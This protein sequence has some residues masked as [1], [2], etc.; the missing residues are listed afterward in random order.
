MSSLLCILD[1]REI[2]ESLPD[3]NLAK[4]VVLPV[5]FDATSSYRLGSASAPYA[6]IEATNQIDTYDLKFYDN[7]LGNVIV[8]DPILEAVQYNEIAR[9]LYRQSLNG[10]FKSLEVLNSVCG[11]VFG[12][13]HS[14]TKFW[15]D[16]GK[17]PI[18][19]GGDNSVSV[20]PVVAY[21]ERYVN[22][23]V[24]HF[25]AHADLRADYQ[26]CI[27]S[28]AA[29]ISNI[30][31]FTNCCVTQVG[32][33]D[34]CED[35]HR[36]I[37]DS[38]GRIVPFFARDLWSESQYVPFQDISSRIAAT[39]SRDVYVCFDM[40]VFDMSLV[41]NTGTPVPGG[42][43]WW[44]VDSILKSVIDSG[45]RIVGFDINE[46]SADGSDPIVAARILHKLIGYSGFTP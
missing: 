9:N 2:F 38:G 35:E 3:H 41:P 45:R 29:A 26:G 15:L 18:V 20:G 5:P 4:Y 42:L 27:H 13:V 17:I 19:L 11:R 31:Q 30:L 36:S 28:H 14:R 43:D 39:L 7:I 25:D 33:R 24:L 46:S 34:L 1:N 12:S 21:S 8:D 44:E 23:S 37:L 10:N 6:V 32:V 22:M 16:Q 40:D